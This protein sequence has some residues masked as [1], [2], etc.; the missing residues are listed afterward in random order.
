MV[1]NER[2]S[3]HFTRGTREDPSRNSGDDASSGERQRGQ[4]AMAI[5]E[6]LALRTAEIKAA[7]RKLREQSAVMRRRGAEI[8]R[9]RQAITRLEAENTKLAETRQEALEA[10]QAELLNLLAAYD[11]FEQESDALLDELSQKNERLR[12]ECKVQN[13]LSV[14]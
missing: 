11:Q 14:L 4:E 7:T 10:K 12:A 2:I 6:T 3:E 8:D 9:L 5:R 1:E 13:K